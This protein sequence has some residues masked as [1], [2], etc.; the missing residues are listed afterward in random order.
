MIC[1]KEVGF[2]AG[3][4]DKGSIDV[5]EAAEGAGVV[6]LDGAAVED[7]GGVGDI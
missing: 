5:V 1:E 3:S 4:T 2:E 7:A 6:G